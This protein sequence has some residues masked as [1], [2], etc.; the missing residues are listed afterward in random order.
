[1]HNDLVHRTRVKNFTK[2]CDRVRFLADARCDESTIACW[3]DFLGNPDKT[4]LTLSMLIDYALAVIRPPILKAIG[5]S[6]TSDQIDHIAREVDRS[7]DLSKVSGFGTSIRVPQQVAVQ[8]ISQYFAADRD[9][10][11]F[12]ARV[13]LNEGKYMGGSQVLLRGKSALL[14]M[15]EAQAWSFDRERGQFVKNQELE[16][17][18]DW[19]FLTE[20][21]EYHLCFASI[22]VVSSTEFRGH[23]IQLFASL[24]DYVK[25]YVEIW[26]GRLWHWMGDGGMVAFHGPD[27]VNRNVVSM[28]AILLN[29]PVF[30][31]KYLPNGPELRIRV[32]SH[33]GTAIYKHPVNEIFSNDMRIAQKLE[34][35]DCEPNRMVITGSVY[36]F[37]KP[38]LYSCFQAGPKFESLETFQ[39]TGIEA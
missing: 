9:L 34:S 30:N 28:L 5:Q 24:R 25:N 37:L 10:L 7:F 12:L 29:I 15:L 17:T 18:A 31:A 13:I 38:E 1:M 19:G 39:L 21:G 23:D 2:F 33:Y 26:N 14:E 8:C 32:A 4:I 6:L 11:A 35:A 16:R 20:G 3:R 27:A 22:D 36:T